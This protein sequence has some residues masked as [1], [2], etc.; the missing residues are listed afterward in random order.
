MPV[1]IQT[2]LKLKAKYPSIWNSNNKEMTILLGFRGEAHMHG[3]G[4]KSAE[5]YLEYLKN[6][7]CSGDYMPGNIEDYRAY[8]QNKSSSEEAVSLRYIQ[9][10]FIQ[11]H[12]LSSPSCNN[13][14]ILL[15]R[16][17]ANPTPMMR[18]KSVKQYKK[19]M[20]SFQEE[21]DHYKS[22]GE[23]ITETKVEHIEV[24]EEKSDLV[25][26]GLFFLAFIIFCHALYY[27]KIPSV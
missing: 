11:L 6:E 16:A 9:Q 24:E 15:N 12:G 20:T 18:E 14:L 26:H 27:A 21:L 1:D 4:F 8:K 13:Q 17:F 2:A 7:W 22:T 5:D 23:F 25:F 3:D 19:Y 10:L